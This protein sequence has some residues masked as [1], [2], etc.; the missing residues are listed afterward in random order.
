MRPILILPPPGESAGGTPVSDVSDPAFLVRA[1]AKAPG[2]RPA[3]RWQCQDALIRLSACEQLMGGRV[4]D[5]EN[6]RSS[7]TDTDRTRIVSCNRNHFERRRCEIE[8]IQSAGR[9]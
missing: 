7:P 2:R 5:P 6:F 4:F 9:G 8:F 3:L 1:R